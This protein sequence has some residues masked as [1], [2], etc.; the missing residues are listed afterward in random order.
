[1]VQYFRAASIN[2]ASKT[3]L[4]HQISILLKLLCKT[5]YNF[6]EIF[7][8]VLSGLDPASPGFEGYSI[9]QRLDPSDAN[10][11]DVIHTSNEEVGL[12]YSIGFKGRLGH[13]DFYPNGGKKQPGCDNET[14]GIWNSWSELNAS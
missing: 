7:N 12:G 6:N 2:L 11:V 1:M 9:D 8:F 13:V 5:E 10:F 14:E 4:R 3:L